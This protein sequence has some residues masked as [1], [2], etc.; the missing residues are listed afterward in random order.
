MAWGAITL[1]IFLVLVATASVGVASYAGYIYAIRS[2][3]FALRSVRIEGTERISKEELIRVAGL[4]SGMNLVSL[5]PRRIE[6]AMLAQPWVKHVSVRRS[7]PHTVVVRVEE[8]R[9]V[10]MLALESLYLVD[11]TGVPFKRVEA[12]DKF[13][14][15][16]ISGLTREQMTG[17]SAVGRA[18]LASA[19]TAV[20]TYASSEAGRVAPLSEVRVSPSYGVTLYAVTGER[21]EFGQAE[22]PKALGR[23][24]RVQTVLASK[25]L[26]AEVIRLDNR[27][28]ENWVT[29]A[30]RA[31]ALGGAVSLR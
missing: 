1:R 21:I 5:S 20:R 11:E 19:T 7:F 22:L 18:M 29:V 14:L 25:G 26:Q 9:A 27:V 24:A 12:S 8:R 2:P 16:L 4:R 31:T 15:P 30:P 10:A 17:N 28:H 13:D 3:T 23:L 6:V